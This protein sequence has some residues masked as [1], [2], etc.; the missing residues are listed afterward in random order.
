MGR[1]SRFSFAL[2]GRKRRARPTQDGAAPQ[3]PK[4]S[5][6]E[7]LLGISVLPGDSKP[8]HH[9]ASLA[10]RNR[11]AVY[12]DQVSLDD[13][14]P[15]YPALSKVLYTKPAGSS[16]PRSRS[17]KNGPS[18]PDI[19]D[20]KKGHPRSMSNGAVPTMRPF[21]S[22]GN[23]S[24]QYTPLTSVPEAPSVQPAGQFRPDRTF[25]DAPTRHGD[26]HSKTLDERRRPSRPDVS[27]LFPSSASLSGSMDDSQ[28]LSSAPRRPSSSSAPSP[29][30]RPSS[31]HK[32][33]DTATGS[34]ADR[35][36]SR[37][38]S[39]A[40]KHWF[41]GLLEAE[42]KIPTYVE[43]SKSLEAPSGS[44]DISI[45]V[46]D[47]SSPI[48]HSPDGRIT[49][50]AQVGPPIHA[51]PLSTRTSFF[52]DAPSPPS[53]DYTVEEQ[54]AAMRRVGSPLPKRRHE[55]LTVLCF[56]DEIQNEHLPK[57]RDSIVLSEL[58]D[59]VT[60][61]EAR[62]F[63]LRPGRV[64]GLT[65]SSPPNELALPS[66][67]HPNVSNTI[68][69]TRRVDQNRRTS[70]QSPREFTANLPRQGKHKLIAVTEEE[71]ALLKMIRGKST[72]T[73]SNSFAQGYKTAL[74]SSPQSPMFRRIR[75]ASEGSAGATPVRSLSLQ[76]EAVV[77][78]VPPL[79][80][81]PSA[82]LPDP[83]EA[84]D[85]AADKA[86]GG[87][88][89]GM[90][91]PR[92]AKFDS[93]S[94]VASSRMS[95]ITSFPTTAAAAAPHA[96]RPDAEGDAVASSPTAPSA[97]SLSPSDGSQASAPLPASPQ[98]PPPS[99]GGGGGGDD[100]GDM[101]GEDGTL[102]IVVADG[103][104]SSTGGAGSDLAAGPVVVL[105]VLEDAA[106]EGKSL[107]EAL[108]DASGAGR[109]RGRA[110][111][112][113][114]DGRWRAQDEGEDEDGDE[115][116]GDEARL[117]AYSRKKPPM[118]SVRPPSYRHREAAATPSRQPY[119]VDDVD[120][121]SSVVDDVM[122]AWN[123]LGGYSLR[124]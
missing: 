109:P 23:L 103:S 110:G 80:P 108:V 14:V 50:V 98:T 45:R 27:K 70:Q 67:R 7:R 10:L 90:M 57:V 88:G 4:L 107:T 29:S 81:P 19:F 31:A 87:G 121:R 44:R 78:I 112:L 100:D 62:A 40:S 32:R 120:P 86:A 95:D 15:G 20:Y 119:E 82:A 37:I 34:A 3:G 104:S 89:S 52:S 68:S 60:I 28:P 113:A 85:D 6:A 91:M 51:Q 117:P 54:P 11:P 69:P 16:V 53:S 122:A 17:V 111:R 116:R 33:P 73:A 48:H 74:L 36:P 92:H 22:A 76:G 58:D 97:V 71:E 84:G 39:R 2:P 35:K 46:V 94:S 25:D 49:V 59:T 26:Q 30:R 38:R 106:R 12:D 21:R 24:S 1:P 66:T 75:S 5:K 65:V 96:L 63:A 83:P 43:D 9:T 105:D 118:L 47:P 64:N 101:G 114:G 115:A 8:Q 93:T 41:D 56:S 77:T 123:S 55:N 102:R 18:S 42:D 79:S 99:R 61:A 13:A 124:E 72:M